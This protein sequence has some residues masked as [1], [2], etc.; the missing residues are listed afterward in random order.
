[1]RTYGKTF[2]PSVAHRRIVHFL[3]QRVLHVEDLKNTF[4]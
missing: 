3:E 4:P 1:L 2:S